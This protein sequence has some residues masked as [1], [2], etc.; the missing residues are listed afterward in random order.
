MGKGFETQAAHTVQTKSEFP[1]GKNNAL[2]NYPWFDL[3][4]SNHDKATGTSELTM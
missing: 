1:P 4:K 3:N 2:F